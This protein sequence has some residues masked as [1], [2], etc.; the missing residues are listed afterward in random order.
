MNTKV[1]CPYCNDVLEVND[2]LDHCNYYCHANHQNTNFGSMDVMIQHFKQLGYNYE[3]QAQQA[4][5]QDLRRPRN[6]FGA[7]DDI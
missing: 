3:T 6:I 7:I 1:N 4:H 5:N 2:L